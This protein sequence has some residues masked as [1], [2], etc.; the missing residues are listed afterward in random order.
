VCE[1]GKSDEDVESGRVEHAPKIYKFRLTE[2]KHELSRME[3]MK[4][5]VKMH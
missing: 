2:N 4:E 3:L 1:I 5:T